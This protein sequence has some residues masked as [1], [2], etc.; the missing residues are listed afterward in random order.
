MV[1]LRVNLRIFGARIFDFGGWFELVEVLTFCQDFV[2]RARG[3]VTKTPPSLYSKWALNTQRKQPATCGQA[4]ITETTALLPCHVSA[5]R[6]LVL[7]HFHPKE[8]N[9]LQ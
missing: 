2:G 9:Y 7:V 6:P 5:Q 4:A 1:W 3:H 8:L